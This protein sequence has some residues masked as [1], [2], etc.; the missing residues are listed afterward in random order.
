M[1]SQ[2]LYQECRVSEKDLHRLLG[3]LV[4]VISFA[5]AA[6]R[7]LNRLLYLLKQTYRERRVSI[8]Y[9][10][11]LDLA[12]LTF[13]LFCSGCA[14]IRKEAIDED[15]AVDACLTGAGEISRLVCYAIEFPRG[16]VDCYFSIASLPVS[17]LESGSANDPKLRGTTRDL[18]FLCA[19]NDCRLS[20]FH[21]PGKENKMADLLS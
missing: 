21:R 17:A 20:V 13:I 2:W 8:S 7:F 19:T 18:W 12:W 3:I 1:Y 10:S 16:I 11:K 4:Q 14:S 15:V 5:P 6:R 9:E